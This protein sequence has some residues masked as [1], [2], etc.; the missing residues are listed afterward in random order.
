MVSYSTTTIHIFCRAAHHA[1]LHRLGKSCLPWL[2]GGKEL[3]RVCFA[4]SRLKAALQ[5]ERAE[6]IKLI[7]IRLGRDFIK[8]YRVD[9]LRRILHK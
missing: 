4:L 8:Y 1:L 3:L 6:D 5:P 2:A 7:E 9:K